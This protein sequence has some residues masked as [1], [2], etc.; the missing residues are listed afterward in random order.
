MNPVCQLD[1]FV[2]VVSM[3]EKGRIFRSLNIRQAGDAASHY[4]DFDVQRESQVFGLQ[5]ER[6]PM[7]T[8]GLHQRFGDARRP[9]NHI[10]NC[11]S[12]DKKAF[13]IGTGR[14]VRTI[15]DD[16]D[17]YGKAISQNLRVHIRH[18]TLSE[19]I[20]AQPHRRTL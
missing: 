7:F 1:V 19:K 5:F 4:Q 17:E 6:Y 16:L 20:V 8:L 13:Q 9:C 2:E 3:A 15:F 10:G 12:L 11:I 14:Q 18:A